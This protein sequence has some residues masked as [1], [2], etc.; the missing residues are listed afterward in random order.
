MVS[1]NCYNRIYN[2]KITSIEFIMV[3]TCYADFVTVPLLKDFYI[4]KL[5]LGTLAVVVDILSILIVY[6]MFGKLKDFNNEFQEIMDNNVIKMSKFT[7][8]L[9]DIKL[10]KTTQDTRILKMKIWLHFTKLL[11]DFQ[12]DE[13]KMEVA[14]VQLANAKDPKFNLLNIMA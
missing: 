4:H 6:Y 10:D 13:N 7:I 1:D 5:T 9:N 12:T 3:S 8:R 2:Q 14:D 11:K